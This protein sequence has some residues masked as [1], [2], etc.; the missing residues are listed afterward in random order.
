[1]D[2]TASSALETTLF[3]P[4][5]PLSV[6][7]LCISLKTA[8][9][10]TESSWRGNYGGLSSYSLQELNAKAMVL[11]SAVRVYITLYERCPYICE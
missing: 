8:L 10:G 3:I 5:P 4:P 9:R 7:S 2:P 6:L 1:M 11:L